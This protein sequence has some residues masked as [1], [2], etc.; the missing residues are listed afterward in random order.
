M[1][2]A[3]VFVCSC[4]FWKKCSASSPPP[5]PILLQYCICTGLTLPAHHNIT[6]AI[7]TPSPNRAGAVSPVLAKY[8]L[9]DNY[10]QHTRALEARQIDDAEYRELKQRVH[11]AVPN[12]WAG[13]V[14]WCK[15][16]A[17]IAATVGVE[18]YMLFNGRT[19]GIGILLGW[20]VLVCRISTVRVFF[21]TEIYTR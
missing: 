21:S 7:L 1:A 10:T 18:L 2:C 5:P 15:C 12:T 8:K 4:V 6:T 17:L 11:A 20:C 19:L 14:F 13:G 16:I 3:R 9:A